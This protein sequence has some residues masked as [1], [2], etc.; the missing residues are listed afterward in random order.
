L[1]AIGVCT[2][3]PGVYDLLIQQQQQKVF[4]GS[5]RKAPLCLF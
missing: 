1:Q 3:V 4:Y 2:Q 5:L